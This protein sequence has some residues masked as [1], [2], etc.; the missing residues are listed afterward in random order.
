[1]TNKISTLKDLFLKE[2][3]DLY[4]AENQLTRALPNMSKAT[5]SNELRTVI[6]NHLNQTKNHVNRLKEIFNQLG[7]KP[8]RT[9]CLAM[10]GL[11]KEGDE[12][13]KESEESSPVRDAAIITAA[14]RVEHYEIAGYGTA[15]CHASVLGQEDVEALLTQ[16]L[17]EEKNADLKLNELAEGF[18]NAQA[19]QVV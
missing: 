17:E 15:R 1:M 2:L 13:L 5:N 8:K 19:E 4:D 18:I 11:I 14:Q 7:E 3:S 16:T 10:Q 6:E 12:V 9:T